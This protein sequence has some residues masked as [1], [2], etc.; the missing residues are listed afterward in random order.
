MSDIRNIANSFFE[1]C[2]T[3]KGWQACKDYCTEDALSLIHI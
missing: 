3:G 2:E 1:S